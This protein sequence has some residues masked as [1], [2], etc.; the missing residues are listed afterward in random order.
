M[1]VNLPHLVEGQMNGIDPQSSHVDPLPPRFETHLH[2]KS[3]PHVLSH[4]DALKSESIH[5]HGHFVY[6][7]IQH[8]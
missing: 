4:L 8:S 6:L 3:K 7:V 1:Q 2:F 5:I